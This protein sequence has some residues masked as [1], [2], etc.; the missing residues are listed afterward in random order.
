MSTSERRSFT[1]DAW[2]ADLIEELHD[3]LGGDAGLSEE[4][5]GDDVAIPP[6]IGVGIIG[7]LGDAPGED[8]LCC[9]DNGSGWGGLWRPLPFI[10]CCIRQ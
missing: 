3:G 8:W 2:F 9:G 7:R 4:E 1:D 6:M 10:V 5:E